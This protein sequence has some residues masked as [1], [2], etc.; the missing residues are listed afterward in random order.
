M[1]PQEANRPQPGD[2]IIELTDIIEKGTVPAAA[3]AVDFDK[4]LEDLFADSDIEAAISN[5]SLP[6]EAPSPAK[7][8]VQEPADTGLDSDIDAF[9]DALDGPGHAA[10]ENVAPK[11]AQPT[12]TPGGRPVN[13]DEQLQMPDMSDMDSLLEQ[14]DAPAATKSAGNIEDLDAGDLDALLDDILGGA[15]A[16]PKAATMTPPPATG[17]EPAP[18]SLD[19][20]DALLDAPVAPA[21][22][23]AP[24][25][26][27]GRAPGTAPMSLDDLDALLDAPVAPAAPAAP[28]PAAGRAPGTATMSLDD[29]DALLDTPVA[30]AT[31]PA[32]EPAAER[33]PGTAAMSLDDIDA[34]FDAPVAPAA[35]AAPEPASEPTP[36]T[37]AMSLDDIDALLDAPVAPAAPAAPEP[38]SEPTPGTATMSLDDIDALLDAP[39]APAAPA[40]PEP[41][42]EPTP[43]TATMSLD[44]IDALLDAPVAPAAPAAPEPAAEPTPGTAAMSLDDID[45]LLDAAPMPPA[46]EEAMPAH[47]TAAEETVIAAMP[48]VQ[49]EPVAALAAETM[50]VAAAATAMA[51]QEPVISPASGPM[52]APVMDANALEG[53]LSRLQALEDEVAGL[54]ATVVH[55]NE[56]TAGLEERLAALDA[57]SAVA[58]SPEPAPAAESAPPAEP[59]MPDADALGRILSEMLAEGHPAMEWLVEQVRAVVMNGMSD[60]IA[61]AVERAVEQTTAPM[62][63]ALSGVDATAEG[64]VELDNRLSSLEATRITADDIAKLESALREALRDDTDKAAAAAAARVIRQEIAALAEIL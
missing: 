57:E 51:P 59:L 62:R 22:P 30:P 42:S 3:D 46:P 26:A 5:L 13:P 60:H 48:P 19:D 33:A 25:P 40:A 34:L 36:G 35:P 4:E 18:M 10:P 27:A 14:L 7:A 56:V 29:I 24:E 52:S 53:L 39:V 61:S 2:D 37:A 1:T 17:A 12:P 43:G 11:L 41:A 63:D 45:A 44:D 58:A 54:R 20:L 50:A 55:G 32:P 21:A 31:P 38:A 23:A 28:E 64:M 49:E 6:D 8:A 15:P 16:S 47:D 9:L